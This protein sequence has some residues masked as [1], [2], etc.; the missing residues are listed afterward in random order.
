MPNSV[1]ALGKNAW[2]NI[3]SPTKTWHHISTDVVSQSFF[4]P[5]PGTRSFPLNFPHS[6]WKIFPK[7]TKVMFPSTILSITGWWF[8]TWMDYCIFPFSWECHHPNWLSLHHFFRGVGQPPTSSPM[9]RNKKTNSH[10]SIWF[11]AQLQTDP[12]L[13]VRL[14]WRPRSS[15]VSCIAWRTALG[16]PTWD[17]Q[18]TNVP[19]LLVSNTHTHTFKQW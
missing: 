19:S 13:V 2:G 12:H 8:G 5:S 9:E 15:R 3:T 1:S 18:S 17:V 6:H 11:K 14:L 7:A 10:G 16:D 4:P